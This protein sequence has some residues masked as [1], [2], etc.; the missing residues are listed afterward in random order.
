[1][2]NKTII[3]LSVA[4]GISSMAMATEDLNKKSLT[5]QTIKTPPNKIRE[6]KSMTL[7][8]RIEVAPILPEILNPES[9]PVFDRQGPTI[10]VA[11]LLDT[12]GSMN[13]LINQARLKIWD[14]ISEI[15][16]ANKNNKEI[17]L[18]VALYQYGTTDASKDSGYINKLN[19][20]SG[21]LDLLSENL[22]N[23]KTSGSEEYSGMAIEFATNDLA[24]SDHPNDLKLI[25]LAGNEE[26]GQGYTPFEYSIPKAKNQ[27]IIV[28]TI[29]CGSYKDGVENEWLKAANIGGGKFFNINQNNKINQI[30]TPYDSEINKLGSEL[31]TTYIK[32]GRLGEEKRARQR[33][34]DMV[35]KKV[36][37]SY[38][39]SRNLAKSSN[40]YNTEDWD[41]VDKYEKEGVSAIAL[42][43]K[44]TGDIGSLSEE[45]IKV[46]LEDKSTKRKEIK[47][48]M[49]KLQ[50]KRS[51]YIANNTDNYSSDFGAALLR[52]VKSQAKEK[53]FTFKK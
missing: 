23:L 53:G 36:S 1:M 33:N 3:A 35:S 31:N 18:E 10:Q 48:E 15:S 8:K 11:I 32:Y 21:D 49:K 50:K 47:S 39:A 41:L 46:Y 42:A 5:L 9:K 20:F 51:N 45:E 30:V 27:N 16:K 28:N 52:V 4:M 38:M 13:G 29:F 24:W 26:M 6:N 37:S 14:I 25:I 2:K 19:G 17:N 44:E 40:A 43:Q 34:Q 7:V 12:S 22:F